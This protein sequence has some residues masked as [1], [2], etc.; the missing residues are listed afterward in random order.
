MAKAAAAGQAHCGAPI[1]WP[2]QA[3]PSG[4]QQSLLKPGKMECILKACNFESCV[5]TDPMSEELG[6]L[7]FTRRKKCLAGIEVMKNLKGSAC[8]EFMLLSR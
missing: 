2:S 6:L 1:S 3:L 4:Y 8:T 5:L 7:P